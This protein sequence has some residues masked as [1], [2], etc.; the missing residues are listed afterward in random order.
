MKRLRGG[1]GLGDSLY[2]RPICDELIRRGE[3]ITVL[4]NYPDVFIGTGAEVKPFCRDNVQVVAH[5]VNGK[6]KAGTTQWQDICESA[7]VQAEMRFT[8][9]IRNLRLVDRLRSLAAGR[10]I[11]LAHGGRAPMGR[12]DGFANDLLPER[13][14]FER[15]LAELRDCF[16]VGIGSKDGVKYGIPVELD[17]TGST[18]VSDLL[19]MA[20][21]C[22]AVIAQCSFAIPLAECFDKPMLAVWSHRVH[23][24]NQAYIKTITPQK[25]L[26]KSTSTFVMDDWTKEQIIEAVNAFRHI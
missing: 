16:V 21:S 24:S 23:V 15:C 6:S 17:M 3:Q 19:D 11:I 9:S 2:V 26:S 10:P 12:S 13:A 7:K 20:Y 1:S 22:D 14:A 8:W 18:S 25:V 4:S 5:Y